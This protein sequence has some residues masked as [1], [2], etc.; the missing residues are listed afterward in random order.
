M[1]SKDLRPILSGWPYKSGQITVRKILG[2]DKSIRI[3]MRLDLGVIQMHEKGRPDGER[4]HNVE[5][6]LEYHTAALEGYV[7]RNGTELGFELTP[8]ECRLLREEAAM[9]Y[10][11][12][13]SL[14]VLEEYEPVE[15]DTARNLRVL[16]LCRK[17]AAEPYDRFVLEQYRPYILMMNTRAKAHRALDANSNRAALAHVEAGLT[18][19]REFYETLG[20]PDGYDACNEVTI[21]KALRGMISKDIPTSPLVRLRRRLDRA[22]SEERYED[23]AEIRD[24][25]RKLETADDGTPG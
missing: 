3:Q 12:Y 23:A 20:Q 7:S 25:I 1:A 2:H 19:I 4:P 10:Y 24:E 17:F 21:L 11:R 14:F 18:A 22:V 5:S 15:R 6:L 8:E 9:Y 13:L 16:D